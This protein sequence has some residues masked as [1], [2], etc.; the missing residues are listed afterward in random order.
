[1]N[2]F[3]EERFYNSNGLLEYFARAE[4]GTRGNEAKWMIRKYFY[5][6]I[7][8]IGKRYPNGNNANIFVLNN[9]ESYSY[10]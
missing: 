7:N 1:M 9:R 3:K 10:S 2:E 8:E 5:E 4:P 6:G